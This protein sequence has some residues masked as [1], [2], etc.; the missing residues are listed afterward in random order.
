MINYSEKNVQEI[1][2]ID[3]TKNKTIFI[4]ACDF[5]FVPKINWII[6]VDNHSNE[7]E[8]NSVHH[9][10]SILRNVH[11]FRTNFWLCDGN[12]TKNVVNDCCFSR[13]WII[14]WLFTNAHMSKFISQRWRNIYWK[15][16]LQKNVT[17]D[18]DAWV[19][20]CIFFVSRLMSHFVWFKIQIIAIHLWKC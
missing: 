17:W 9:T 2:D 6:N 16:V 19:L 8:L 4:F 5:F 13:N 15:R 1:H 7:F 14:Q 12:I 20:P 3:K 10:K 11:V 18:A